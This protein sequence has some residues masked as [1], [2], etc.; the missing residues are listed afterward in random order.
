MN[1]I[2]CSFIERKNV[3]G[4]MFI[5]NQSIHIT[6]DVLTALISSEQSPEEYI[7]FRKDYC[8]WAVTLE[9]DIH[10]TYPQM[11]ESEIEIIDIMSRITSSPSF[12]KSVNN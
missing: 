11:R 2:I 8:K 9:V 7:E 10:G 1:D 6:R 5:M 12:N 3:Y 4:F